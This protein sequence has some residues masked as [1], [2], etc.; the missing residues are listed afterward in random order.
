MFMPFCLEPKGADDPNVAQEISVGNMQRLTNQFG[1]LFYRYRMPH[2]AAKGIK[3][4][5]EQGYLVER[6]DELP[7]VQEWVE[8]Y[9]GQLRVAASPS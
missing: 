1:V 6:I 4:K 9:S 5:A 7:K 8:T 2:Y 3:V